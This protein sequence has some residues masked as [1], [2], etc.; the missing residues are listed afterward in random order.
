MRD[1]T[2]EATGAS[3]GDA[4]VWLTY[5]E[6]GDRLGISPASVKR[7]ANRRKWPKRIGN[8][9]LSLVAVPAE[10]LE[11][12]PHGRDVAGD[13]AEDDAGDDASDYKLLAEHLK[14]EL[15]EVK[16][17]ALTLRADLRSAEG[18]A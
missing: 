10:V 3:P 6:L 8:D 5:A 7:R 9:G 13:D 4:S 11:A 2:S 15:Q 16:A 12:G 17:S 18:E 1:I 14:V